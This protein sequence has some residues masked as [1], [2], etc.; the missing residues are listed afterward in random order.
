[1][2]FREEGKDR[3]AGPA[4]VTGTE[5]NKVRVIHSGY[6]RTVP[7]C[8]VIP[9]K[10]RRDIVEECIDEKEVNEDNESETSEEDT[11]HEF[12]TDKL[13]IRP[14]WN[15]EVQFKV[16]G[17]KVVGKVIKV[18]KAGGKDK[19]RCWIKKKDDTTESFDFSKDIE[20]WQLIQKVAFGDDTKEEE[21][22]E[23]EKVKEN[24][25]LEFIFY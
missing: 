23:K 16:N 20:S 2:F 6:D 13:D 25:H 24:D 14:K 21:S 8:R 19:Y 18:G 15:Q 9:A 11:V 10:A 3:L 5:G 1:M 12:D 4:Q 17:V 7:K 22:S